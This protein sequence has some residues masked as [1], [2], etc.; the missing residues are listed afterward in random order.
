MTARER[1]RLI[2][3]READEALYRLWKKCAIGETLFYEVSKLQ[4]NFIHPEI[5]KLE[6]R[7]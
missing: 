3:L 6:G 1:E 4:E 7:L 5:R 2:A